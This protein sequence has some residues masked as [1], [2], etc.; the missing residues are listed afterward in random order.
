MPPIR[1]AVMASATLYDLWS[2]EAVHPDLIEVPTWMPMEEVRLYR[3]LLPGQPLLVHGGNLL[4]APLTEA[5]SEALSFLVKECTPPWVSAHIS[6]WPWKVLEDAR[7]RGRQPTALDLGSHL[8]R[9]FARVRMLREYLGIPLVLENAPGL[10]GWTNDPESDP[11][12]IAAVLEA[13]GC[14]FLLDLSYAQTAANNWG[15]APEQY[16]ESLPLSRVV[17]IHVSAP[18]VLGNGRMMDVHDPLREED[19]YLLGWL[20]ERTTP[21][22]VTLEFWKEP[23]ALHEQVMRLRKELAKKRVM[24]T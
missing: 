10:P 7:Q 21:Q 19:Y 9:S 22:I 16:L 23:Q 13:T 5:Q 15:Y 18:S 2:A 4:G 8:E 24:K 12:T 6:L 11:G 17:E 3:S 20:L 14:N 1:L